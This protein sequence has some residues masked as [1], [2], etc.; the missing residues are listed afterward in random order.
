ASEILCR[1]DLSVLGAWAAATSE[2]GERTA[3]QVISGAD[4]GGWAVDLGALRSGVELRVALGAARPVKLFAL[5]WAQW[6][7][8]VEYAIAAPVRGATVTLADWRRP[9]AQREVIPVAD[10]ELS[11][12]VIRVRATGVKANGLLLEQVGC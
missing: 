10:A 3:V 5:H 12:Y 4:T 9:A 2:A 8:P 11:E 6:P 7:M 1:W